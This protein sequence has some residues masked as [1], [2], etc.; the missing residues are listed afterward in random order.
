MSEEQQTEIRQ[1]MTAQSKKYLE[2]VLDTYPEEFRKVCSGGGCHDVKFE[3]ETLQQLLNLINLQT[4]TKG[5]NRNNT[6]ISEEEFK[7]RSL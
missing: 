3:F 7:L 1:K 5:F 4:T 6:Q 2:I